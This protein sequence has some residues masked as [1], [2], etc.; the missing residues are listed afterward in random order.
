MLYFENFSSQN[1]LSQ[2]SGYT[3]TQDK[4]GFMW[5]GTQDGLNRFDGYDFKIFRINE[6]S[7]SLRSNFISALLTD[8][9]GKIWIGTPQGLAVYLPPATEQKQ[10][11]KIKLPS[12]LKGANILKL[13]EDSAERIWILTQGNGVFSFDPATG[14]TARFDV[15]LAPQHI[16]GITEDVQQNIWLCSSRELFLLGKKS[17]NI[18]NPTTKQA[19]AKASSKPQAVDFI[20]ANLPPDTATDNPPNV[21]VN[22]RDISSSQNEL[23]IATFS[24]GIYIYTIQNGSLRFKN[25]LSKSSSTAGLASNEITCLMKDRKENMWIG[26]RNS[27]VYVYHPSNNKF[28]RGYQGTAANMLSKNFV[29][30]LFEDRQG[31]IWI[32]LSGGGVSKYDPGKLRFET[33][34]KFN[35]ETESGDDMIFTIYEDRHKY[36]LIGTQSSGLVKYDQDGKQ[37]TSFR[38]SDSPSSIIHNTIYGIAEDNAGT[39]WLATWGG[40][41]AYEPGK[42]DEKAFTRYTP[43]NDALHTNFYA[44]HKIKNEESL[45]LSG[46]NGLVKFNLRTNQFQSI[47][48]STGFTKVNKIVARMIYETADGIF[49]LATERLGLLRYSPSEKHIRQIPLPEKLPVTVR[50]ILPDGLATLWLATDEGLLKFNTIT[51]QVERRWNKQTGLPSDVIY[52]VLKDEKD[53]L[54]L[55]SNEGLCR[56]DVRD[57]TIRMFDSKDG[58]QGM[59]FNTASCLKSKSGLFYFGGI[60]GI[61]RFQPAALGTSTYHPEAVITGFKVN[62]EELYN[63][64]FL[65]DYS[66]IKLTPDQNFIRIDFS[67]LNFSNTEKNSYK[68][69]LSD[70]DRDWVNIGM[71]RSVNYTNLPPG[72]YIFEILS[73]NGD[74]IQQAKASLLHFY[75]QPAWYQTGWFKIS[76]ILFTGSIIYGLFQYRI[77]EIKK[78]AA[79]MKKVSETEMMA[80]RAQMNPHFIFNCLNSIQYYI[81]INQKESA[82]AF[83]SKFSRLIR[84]ILENSMNITVKLSDEI[85]MLTYYIDMERLRLEDK[86]EATITVEEG[87]SPDRIEIPPLL[88]QPYVENAILH[89]LRYKIGQGRLI[90]SIK[91]SDTS[92]ICII[93]DNGIGREKS[94]ALNKKQRGNHHSAGQKLSQRRIEV[95]QQSSPGY[96]Q[97]AVSITDLNKAA[98][99]KTGTRVE[100]L[101]PLVYN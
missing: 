75:I 82:I 83:L 45:L 71:Q 98:H 16:V 84:L 100:I 15:S 50:H 99:R 32:G 24:K 58:L 31:I 38:T 17:K 21:P 20:M 22:I 72:D 78:E 29:L 85:E 28:S 56:L 77:N 19:T 66:A 55:S 68:H 14:H 7:A 52:A 79:F 6:D 70:I 44:V 35:P 51:N 87:I 63:R 101:L 92:L 47:E 41:C 9:S 48:D 91:K 74:G 90:L 65:P 2:N 33:W 34:K 97:A 59:E 25:Q 26:T 53:G 81:A 49:W 93:E 86:F 80:L 30:S 76:L 61:N 89:G 95:L 73:K 57:N 88:L 46:K 10:R 94:A 18:E 13:F 64:D 96:Q 27:G 62:N 5:F 1:G 4:T 60:N 42:A 11:S 36:L 69:K 23:W 3:I 40:L 12:S 54:W 37:F 39:L 67:T 8:A 43:E